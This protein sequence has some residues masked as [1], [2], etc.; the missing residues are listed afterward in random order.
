MTAQERAAEA[1]ARSE[2]AKVADVANSKAKAN[3]YWDF[4]I[5]NIR[6]FIQGCINQNRDWFSVTPFRP[7]IIEHLKLSGDETP[8]P[9]A[10]LSIVRKARS[11]R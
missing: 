11:G 9:I 3:F 5:V 6:E 2:A 8:A 1:L 4:E 7:A 10:G